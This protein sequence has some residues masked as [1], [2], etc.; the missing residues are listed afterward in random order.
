MSLINSNKFSK[1]TYQQCLF[2][3]MFLIPSFIFSQ[4]WSFGDEAI[5]GDDID[6]FGVHLRSYYNLPDEKIC[7][8]LEYS[9]FFEQTK[10]MGDA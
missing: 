5:Y 9:Y 3:I 1:I 6:T 4:S 10:I 7:F 8:G 2:F